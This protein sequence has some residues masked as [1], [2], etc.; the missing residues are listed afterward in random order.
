M[1]EVDLEKVGSFIA[2]LRK[3]KGMTQEELANYLMVS[4]KAVSKWEGG[5]N[6]PDIECQRKICKLFNIS[7]EELHSGE[8]N[9]KERAKNKKIHKQNKTFKILLLSLIPIFV[10]LFSYFIINFRAIKLYYSKDIRNND[11]D[12]VFVDLM[13]LNNNKKTLIALSNVSLVDYEIQ[14]TDFTTLNIYSNNIKIYTTNEIRNEIL[15]FKNKKLD[16]NNIKIEIIITTIDDEIKKYSSK[17]DLHEISFYKN[18]TYTNDSNNNHQLLAKEDII[19][20]LE[21]NDFIKTDNN[22]YQKSIIT[23][24]G[25]IK[26]NYN[27]HFQTVDIMYNY[28]EYAIKIKAYYDNNQFNAIVYNKDNLNIAIEKY[29]YDYINKEFKCETGECITFKKVHNLVEKYVTL[30]EVE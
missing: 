9:V 27:I 13:I 14:A 11:N 5:K 20:K 2:I 28:N 16:L 30:P 25:S 6:L 19:K 29:F 17:L 24:D 12:T 1:E 26:V 23:K 3:E 7:M 8:R 4:D 10:F 21:D 22:I 15:F 18:E